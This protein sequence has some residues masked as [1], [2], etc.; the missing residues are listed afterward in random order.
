MCSFCELGGQDTR[1]GRREVFMQ[2]RGDAGG[3]VLG[4]HALAGHFLGDHGEGL[5]GGDVVEEPVGGQ[6]EHVAGFELDRGGVG[7]FRVVENVFRGMGTLA[8]LV[9]A[10][11][12][13]ENGELERGVE[14]VDLGFGGVGNLALAKDEKTRIAEVG[15]VQGAGGGGENADAGGGPAGLDFVGIDNVL[16]SAVE[17]CFRRRQRRRRLLTV[18]RRQV[19]REQVAHAITQRLRKRARVDPNLRPAA[20][21]VRHGKGH[22]ARVALRRRVKER[23]LARLWAC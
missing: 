2:G 13:R 9:L 17:Q 19:R 3:G 20:D 22:A 21:A 6:H 23:V 5:G 15:H 1:G 18:L 4:P 16:V 14:G 8:R 12:L 10:D 11:G 7:I